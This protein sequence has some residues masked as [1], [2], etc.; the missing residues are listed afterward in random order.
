MYEFQG[1]CDMR[2]LQISSIQRLVV[3]TK[4]NRSISAA[5]VIA[6]SNSFEGCAC[7][8]ILSEARTAAFI[9]LEKADLF[10]WGTDFFFVIDALHS[11]HGF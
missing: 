3:P 5:T 1:R 7:G 4:H 11:I 9:V 10:D 6:M 2:M 8:R